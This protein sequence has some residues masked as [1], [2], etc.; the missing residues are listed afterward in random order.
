MIELLVCYKPDSE[1][2]KRNKKRFLEYWKDWNVTLLEDYNER[3]PAFNEA[4]KKSSSEF[5]ALTDI[6]AM[7]P[8]EQMQ[9]LGDV[10]Y[11]YSQIYNIDED[12]GIGKSWGRYWRY[13]LM[14][15]FNREKFLEFGGEN[16]EFRGYGWDDLERYFRALNYGLSVRQV[17]GPAYHMEHD[18]LNHKRHQSL[19]PHYMKNWQLMQRERFKYEIGSLVG[20]N[21]NDVDSLFK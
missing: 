13:G 1:K 5:I 9:T 2:R 16:E 8:Y 3:A 15:I 7:V 11:P 12:N 18:E 14:I 19:N 21:S 10:T 4:A 6:D 17:E 20:N